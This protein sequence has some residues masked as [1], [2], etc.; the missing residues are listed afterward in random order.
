MDASDNA[1]AYSGYEGALGRQVDVIDANGDGSSDIIA[2]NKM[3]TMVF[4]RGRAAPPSAQARR[5]SRDT[6]VDK[7]LQE[8]I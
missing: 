8:K 5:S 7:L 2:G 6:A 1:I 4:L 3:G